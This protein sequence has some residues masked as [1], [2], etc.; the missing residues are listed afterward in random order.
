[1]VEAFPGQIESVTLG[2]PTYI[3][4]NAYIPYPV[5][6][7]DFFEKAAGA[8][9]METPIS[10]GELEVSSTVQITYAILN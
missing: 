5:Y 7:P 2:K 8:P 3:T 10:P 6:R 9:A 1:L 4:E